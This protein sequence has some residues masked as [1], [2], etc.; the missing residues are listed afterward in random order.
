MAAPK[1]ARGNVIRIIGGRW[2][3]RRIAVP[4]APGCRPTGDR[5]RETLFNWL[6]PWLPGA[7]CADLCAGTGALG[8]EALSQGAA[9]CVFVD[10]NAA[11][12]RQLG[13]VRDTIG[14]D[15]STL[16]R[17]DAL[18]WLKSNTGR[19]DIVFLDPPFDSGLAEPLLAALLAGG[20]L[21]DAALVYCETPRGAP[22]GEPGRW[23]EV[24]CG[25]TAQVDYR[26]LS[27]R[28]EQ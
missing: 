3:G 7:R 25:H 20:H 16:V 27:P 5:V 6:R 9:H 21:A 2:R 24:R 12:I 23:D 28:A 14:A 19:F 13:T 11:L 22:A 4:D 10:S 26:L 1:R 18:A 8:L 15:A 17:A